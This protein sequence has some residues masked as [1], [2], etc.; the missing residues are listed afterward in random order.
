MLKISRSQVAW[1]LLPFREPEARWT[2]SAFVSGHLLDMGIDN[3]L[4]LLALAQAQV[5]AR[6]SSL[7]AFA[8][9][10][11]ARSWLVPHVERGR[12]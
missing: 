9:A 3:C 5:D 1:W 11:I 10:F 8:N 7:N 2:P 12:V 6:D 4:P